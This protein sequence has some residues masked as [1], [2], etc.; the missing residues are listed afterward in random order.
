[1]EFFKRL[2]DGLNYVEYPIPEYEPTYFDRHIVEMAFFHN[3]IFIRKGSNDEKPNAP[4]LIEEELVALCGSERH[5]GCAPSTGREAN[6][7]SPEARMEVHREV[8]LQIREEV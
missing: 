3:L 7:E 4:A 8:Q 6:P 1:M 5:A 2:A